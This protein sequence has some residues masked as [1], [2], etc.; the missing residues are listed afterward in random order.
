[1]TKATWFLLFLLA[2][3]K[4]VRWTPTPRTVRYHAAAAASRHP[5]VREH[6]STSFRVQRRQRRLS[7]MTFDREKSFRTK[8][9]SRGGATAAVNSPAT[10]SP[11]NNSTST[12]FEKSVQAI[13]NIVVSVGRTILPPIF[14]FSRVTVAFYRTLPKDAIAAQAGLVYCFAGGY[15]PTLFA[16]LSAAQNCG[17]DI[18]MHACEDLAD[19]AALAIDA[20]SEESKFDIDEMSY[21]AKITQK[22]LIVLKT[23]DPVKVSYSTTNILQTRTRA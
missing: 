19:Q 2:P 12:S 17:W 16:A 1:M 5:D 13:V 21:Q 22:T 9:I 6:S 18:M 3:V 4:S 11:A 14:E 15:Y 23:V 10:P 8:P 7:R 20:L